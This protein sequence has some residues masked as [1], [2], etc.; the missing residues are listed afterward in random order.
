MSDPIADL[1]TRI[2][3]SSTAQKRYVHIP[4]SNTKMNIVKVLK[5]KGF[6]ADFKIVEIDNFKQIKVF[7]K[8]TADRV[9]VIKQLKRE[10][11]P[12]LRKY[13]QV[14]K[15]PNVLGG[16]GI[17]I[18]STSKGVLDGQEAKKQNLGGELLCV[19]W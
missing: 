15:I 18:V 11:K 6:I 14:D 7:L 16:M 9:P 8:Y 3:N 12:G 10:S 19:V 17:S 1:L 5:D 4:F 2:R 13:V